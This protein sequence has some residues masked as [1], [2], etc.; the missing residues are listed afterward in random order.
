MGQARATVQSDFITPPRAALMFA[1]ATGAASSLDLRTVGQQTG[2]M[3]KANSP[4]SGLVG[5]YITM[6]AETTDVYYIFGLTSASVTSANAP[7]VATA[8][9]NAA[10]VCMRLP[11]G[12][13]VSYK[14]EEGV[15][16]FIGFMASSAGILRIHQSSP[17]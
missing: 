16:L 7:V 6:H 8:G 10:G 4:Q 14:L 3:S 1:V 5:K 2:D 9:T 11:A 13:S 12:Q 15:D 17:A